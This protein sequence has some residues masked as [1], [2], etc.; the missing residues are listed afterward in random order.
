MHFGHCVVDTLH[1]TVAAH[2]RIGASGDFSYTNKFADDVRSL[3]A[4]MEAVFREGAMRALPKGNVPVDK[5]SW[6]Y[7]QLDIQLR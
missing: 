7:P 5:D 3:G 2:V 4:E 6:A 1:T